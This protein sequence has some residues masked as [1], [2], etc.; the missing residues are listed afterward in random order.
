MRIKTQSLSSLT[1]KQLDVLKT[2]EVIRV[3]T[4]GGNLFDISKDLTVRVVSNGSVYNAKNL[5]YAKFYIGCY[6]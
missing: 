6:L 5:T 3:K 1:R 4:R 2:G